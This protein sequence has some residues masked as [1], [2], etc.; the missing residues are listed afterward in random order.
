MNRKGAKNAKVIPFFLCEL[1]VFAVQN[2]SNLMKLRS[3]VFR[4]LDLLFLL[5]LAAYVVAG[6]PLVPFHGDEPTL[7]Y[8]SHDYDYQ[9]IQRDLSLVEYS[10]PPIS[11]QEQDLRLLNGTI[12][13]YLIGLVMASWWFYRR[14]P[15]RAVGLERRLELQP[16]YRT[17]AV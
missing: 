7:I 2:L 9:F 16:D 12:N 5:A 6:M 1:G 10:D 13:K 11:A 14:R 4:L 3:S 8:M 17:R 15:Q